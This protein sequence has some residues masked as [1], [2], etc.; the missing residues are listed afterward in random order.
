MFYGDHP[1][2]H[3]HV[4]YGDARA[5]ID[6]ERLQLLAGWLPA[7]VHGLAIE[8]GALHQHD[9]IENWHRAR[10]LEPLVPIAPLE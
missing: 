1:P 2:P 7:R 8:W 6:I 3:C 10:R 9:L 5:V 4:R